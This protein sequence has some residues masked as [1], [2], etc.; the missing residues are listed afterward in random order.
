MCQALLPKR[1]ERQRRSGLARSTT[2]IL[3]TVLLFVLVAAA[4]SNDQG[5]HQGHLSS[6]PTTAPAGGAQ[7]DGILAKLDSEDQALLLNAIAEGEAVAAAAIATEKNVEIAALQA[8][9]TRTLREHR[10]L[11]EPVL[12]DEDEGIK[13]DDYGRLL[14]T[15]SGEERRRQLLTSAVTLSL[16]HI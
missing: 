1:M 5:S 13:A 10:R 8:T 16:I 9:L 12:E 15:A 2:F 3:F 6:K 14:P 4:A 11:R 7:W